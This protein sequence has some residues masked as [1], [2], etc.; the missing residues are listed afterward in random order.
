MNDRINSCCLFFNKKTNPMDQISLFYPYDLIYTSAYII[1]K[2]IWGHTIYT[3]WIAK[4]FFY[5]KNVVLQSHFESLH[6]VA[7]NKLPMIYLITKIILWIFKLLP[8]VHCY[9]KFHSEQ[10]WCIFFYTFLVISLWKTHRNY[11]FLVK[12]RAKKFV[13]FQ[14]YLQKDCSSLHFQQW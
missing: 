3:N 6:T 2:K 5:P 7:L 8:I 12:P 4:E 14:I 10:S 11:D 13:N 1:F 9:E